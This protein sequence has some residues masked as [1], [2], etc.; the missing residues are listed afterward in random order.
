MILVTGL[1]G[2][3]GLTAFLFV[4]PVEIA[5]HL[6]DPDVLSA[7]ERVLVSIGAGTP[8]STWRAS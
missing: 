4:E 7:P 5:A 3:A 1:I 8:G 2:V 6:A